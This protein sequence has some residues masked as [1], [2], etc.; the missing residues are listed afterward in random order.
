MQD[1]TVGGRPLG[2]HRAHCD[3]PVAGSMLL[4]GERTTLGYTL[5]QYK[6]LNG[7]AVEDAQSRVRK[8]GCQA[9]GLHRTR[10]ARAPPVTR[11]SNYRLTRYRLGS[12]SGRLSGNKYIYVYAGVLATTS[13]EL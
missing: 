1:Q 3:H 11:Y 4:S 6:R 5:R 8:A 7:Q 9:D 13:T 12:L 10:R 2:G